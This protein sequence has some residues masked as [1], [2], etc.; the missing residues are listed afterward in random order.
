MSCFIKKIIIIY[1]LATILLSS[2]SYAD[3]SKSN[4]CSASCVVVM[5]MRYVNN[6]FDWVSCQNN[7]VQ[8]ANINACCNVNAA[9][10]LQNGVINP[11]YGTVDIQNTANTAENNDRSSVESWETIDLD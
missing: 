7:S 9:T 2:Q 3:Q 11:H 5:L 6:F 4:H 1:F 8:E 10:A